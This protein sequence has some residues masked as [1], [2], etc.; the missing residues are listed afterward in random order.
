MRTIPMR[1]LKGESEMFHK[2]PPLLPVV[3]LLGAATASAPALAQ[4]R[5]HHV[6]QPH[7]RV[8]VSPYA[9]G[10]PNYARAVSAY[11]FAPSATP[12]TGSCPKMEGYPDCH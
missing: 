10:F 6:M 4:T 2:L 5:S 7:R 9:G 1:T 3:I 11:A 12:S 8:Q